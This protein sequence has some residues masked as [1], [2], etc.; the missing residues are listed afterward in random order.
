MHTQWLPKLQEATEAKEEDATS[1]PQVGSSPAIALPSAAASRGSHAAANHPHQTAMQ[2]FDQRHN[3]KPRCYL[4]RNLHVSWGRTS[5]MPAYKIPQ[6]EAHHR[7]YLE[8][9]CYLDVI[10]L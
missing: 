4:T 1:E 9:K 7:H 5:R 10:C 2:T 3:T 6:Q 8:G